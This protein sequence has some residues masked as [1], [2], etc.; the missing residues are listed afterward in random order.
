MELGDTVATETASGAAAA[1]VDVEA[2][3]KDCCGGE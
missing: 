3:R 1:E 2:M